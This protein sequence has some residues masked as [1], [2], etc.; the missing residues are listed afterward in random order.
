M[1]RFEPQPESQLHGEAWR[2]FCSHMASRQYGTEELRDAWLF[3]LDGWKAK[4]AQQE[5]IRKRM[6]W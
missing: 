2:R 4:A 1:P 6:R 5:E 3:F